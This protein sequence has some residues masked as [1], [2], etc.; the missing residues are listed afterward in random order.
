MFAGLS[1]VAAQT[2]RL[3]GGQ[4]RLYNTYKTNSIRLSTP[5]EAVSFIKP[6][7]RVF[8]H[9]IC[10]FPQELVDA[11][12]ARH[13][14]LWDVEI[15]HLHI[16]GEPSYINGQAAESFRV[17]N[18][19]IGKKLRNAVNAGLADYVPIF[20][21]EI[22]AL[23][24]SGRL[25]LNAALISVSPPDAHGFCSL[26]P[27]VD[28]ALSA[29]RHADLVIAQVNKKLPRTHGA[30]LIH[31]DNINYYTEV[32]TAIHEMPSEPLS[33]AEMAVGRNLAP[34]I[35]NGSTLQ[36]GIG[37]VPQALC[38]FL[39]NHSHLGI[40]TELISDSILPLIESGVID[41]SRKVIFPGQVVASFLQGTKKLWDYVDD[42][43]MV[44]LMPSEYVND[45]KNIQRNPKVVAINSAIEIDLTGQICADSV[46][47]RFISGIGGQLDF[48][49][50]ASLSPGG[51]P[52]IA[53]LSTTKTGES[54]INTHLKRGSGVVTT[55]AHVHWVVTEYGA[56][57]LFGLNVRQR[58]EKLISIAHPDHREHLLKEARDRLHL[59]HFHHQVNVEAILEGRA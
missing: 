58:A 21:S 46:G 15:C 32:D 8:I 34:L 29:V 36:L 28:V 23:F 48:E 16:A 39:E 26:G 37:A 7:D 20:L 11:L 42:N 44:A 2:A 50:G 53:M 9:G 24:S 38:A 55:R 13:H 19:F 47:T 43:P 17:N 14:S 45:V 49:R 6:G 25:P 33:E 10:S 54:R 22:P 31:M 51:K 35:E 57:N 18:L 30:G 40:H 12:A 1:R 41:N 4:R 3:Q 27:S 5:S 59:G 56:V 52:V